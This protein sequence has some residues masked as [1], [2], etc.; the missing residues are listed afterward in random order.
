[1][2]GQNVCPNRGRGRED[3]MKNLAD[4]VADKLAEVGDE[5]PEALGSLAELLSVPKPSPPPEDP[6]AAPTEEA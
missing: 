1:M 2:A 6:P 3:E 4:Q 5:T